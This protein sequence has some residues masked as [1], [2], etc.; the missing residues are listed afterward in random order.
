[1]ESLTVALRGSIFVSVHDIVALL[2]TRLVSTSYVYA[3]HMV[4]LYVFGGSYGVASEDGAADAGADGCLSASLE[5]SSRAHDCKQ[6]AAGS[7]VSRNLSLSGIL[8][9][10]LAIRGCGGPLAGTIATPKQ[11]TRFGK[12]G[13]NVHTRVNRVHILN[14]FT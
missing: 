12:R 14:S 8:C 4:V 11:R 2:L 13:N 6:S 3:K 9:C 10:R 1:M 7:Q 5:R